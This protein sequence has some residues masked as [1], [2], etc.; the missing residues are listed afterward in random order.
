MPRREG[1]QG[2]RGHACSSNLGFGSGITFC[3]DIEIPEKDKQ[4]KPKDDDDIDIVSL[5]DRREVGPRSV[6]H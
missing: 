4:R 5:E 6:C 2:K 3:R 1:R